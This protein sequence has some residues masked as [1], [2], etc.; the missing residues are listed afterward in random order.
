V[1]GDARKDVSV[2]IGGS[3]VTHREFSLYFSECVFRDNLG[4]TNYWSRQIPLDFV[5]TNL[6]ERKQ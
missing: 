4:V 3:A 2:F 5:T 6:S 1:V